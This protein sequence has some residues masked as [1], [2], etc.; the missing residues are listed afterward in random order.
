MIIKHDL[1][2]V[3]LQIVTTSFILPALRPDPRSRWA[4]VDL[5]LSVCICVLAVTAPHSNAKKCLVS[6]RFS[7][8]TQRLNTC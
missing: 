8:G 6:M 7:I 4:A 2:I 5:C 3:L 1:F